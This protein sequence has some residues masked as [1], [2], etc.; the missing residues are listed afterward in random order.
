[1]SIGSAAELHHAGDRRGVDRKRVAHRHR[2]SIRP[3]SSKRTQTDVQK[4]R[5]LIAEHV[6]LRLSW[7]VVSV[8]RHGDVGLLNCSCGVTDQLSLVLSFVDIF[9]NRSYA[10]WSFTSY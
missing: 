4:Y 3:G 9:E 6:G 5:Q 2:P 8:C 1:R 7:Q 10:F